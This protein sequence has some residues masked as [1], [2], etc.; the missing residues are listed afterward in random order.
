MVSGNNFKMP[1]VKQYHH[2]INRAARRL[3]GIHISLARRLNT[4]LEQEALTSHR[5]SFNAV[6][7]EELGL[8]FNDFREALLILTVESM[9][10][11]KGLFLISDLRQLKIIH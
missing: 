4:W 9:T 6:I 1:F 7:D 3:H 5:Q 8:E 11:E 10:E 2:Q